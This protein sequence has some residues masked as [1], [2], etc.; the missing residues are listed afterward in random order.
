MK[1]IF[2]HDDDLSKE[3][4][5]SRKS[6]KLTPMNFLAHPNKSSSPSQM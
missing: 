3:V 4:P 5:Q 1:L 6:N 2:N